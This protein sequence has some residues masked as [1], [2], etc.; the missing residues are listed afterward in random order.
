MKKLLTLLLISTSFSCL[1]HEAHAGG[2][3]SICQKPQQEH[4]DEINNMPRLNRQDRPVAQIPGATY[5]STPLKTGLDEESDSNDIAITNSP[6]KT[7]VLNVEDIAIINSVN[8]KN[9]LF[10][11][12]P[13]APNLN[14]SS[15]SQTISYDIEADYTKF[16]EAGIT[17]V[18]LTYFLGKLNDKIEEIEI[19]YT[20]ITP[21]KFQRIESQIE[22][23]RK[24]LEEA[25][26]EE[27]KIVNGIAIERLSYEYKKMK[28]LKEGIKGINKTEEVNFLESTNVDEQL[29]VLE[30]DKM[31]NRS[32]LIDPSEVSN[33][34]F[35]QLNTLLS[36]NP[37][38]NQL[39]NQQNQYAEK[40]EKK[41]E[42]AILK[43]T[44]ERWNA[45]FLKDPNKYAPNQL[46]TSIKNLDNSPLLAKY[47][48]V[49]KKYAHEIIEKNKI[50]T[51]DLT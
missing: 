14:F 11:K 10:D 50:I 44:M 9:V 29:K 1:L 15:V 12:L 43:S 42:K 45:N 33:Y 34:S 31:S 13:I 23:F 20:N 49:A 17:E 2:F 4:F 8:E 30:V 21:D 28:F 47:P 26:D 48:E 18:E 40:L 19:D 25:K 35:D 7:A 5:L 27:N 36:N 37:E 39:I 6:K 51:K 24:K 38:W 32:I 46:L 3:P 16:I 41:K 22:K